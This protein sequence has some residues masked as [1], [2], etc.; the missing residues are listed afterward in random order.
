MGVHAVELL[1]SGKNGLAVFTQSLEIGDCA[2]NEALSIRDETTDLYD[3]LS[4][5]N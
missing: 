2:I 1:K 5:L 4:K 3:Y